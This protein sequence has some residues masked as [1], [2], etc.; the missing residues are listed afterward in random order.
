MPL[1]TRRELSAAIMVAIAVPVTGS[2]TTTS[3]VKSN[4]VADRVRATLQEDLRNQFRGFLDRASIADLYF[5]NGVM[6]L[7]QAESLGVCARSPEL[8]LPAAF[9]VQVDRG[10]L[11]FVAVPEHLQGDA[12]RYVRM[13]VAAD[14]RGGSSVE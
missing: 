11:C 3:A 10:V 13:L 12:E 9:Q 1:I 2:A 14:G 8:A 4:S 6:G 5:L 7:H